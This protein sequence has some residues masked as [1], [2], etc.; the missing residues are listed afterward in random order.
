[1]VADCVVIG[2]GVVGIAVARQLGL[3]GRRV[4]VLEASPAIGTVTSSRNSEVI[5]AGIYYPSQSL[6]ARLCVNGRKMLYDYCRLNGVPHK[7]LGKLIVATSTLQNNVLEKLHRVGIENGVTDL[8]MMEAEEAMAMEPQLRCVKAL[9][10]PST[11]IIDTHSLMLAFQGE[12]EE[13]GA[14]FAFNTSVV[15]GHIKENSIHLHISETKDM[16]TFVDNPNARAQ[17]ILTSNVVINSAGLSATS[18]ARRFHGFPLQSIPNTYY[19]RGCY[20]TLS[21]T[22]KVPFSHLVYPV[23]EEG[24]LGVHVTVDMGGQVRF[25][26]DVEWMHEIDDATSFLNMF[27]YTVDARRAEF[28][29]PEIRKYYPQLKDGTLRPDYSGIRPKLYGPGQPAADF[30]IQHKF[31]TLQNQHVILVETYLGPQNCF[32]ITVTCHQTCLK[33]RQKL[34]PPT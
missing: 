17:M 28:F 27:K 11:G 14:T 7:Q 20:F 12:A 3:A 2:G 29:Y 15:R 13:H 4:V 8:R 6:K 26:P 16:H 23:P 31:K 19:A 1:V 5:H 9:C 21:E 33:T 34:C 10:S 24:G 30:V 22:Q 18:L 32:G 25:G